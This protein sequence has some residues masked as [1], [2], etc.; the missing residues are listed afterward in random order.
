MIRPTESKLEC[1]KIKRAIKNNS[2]EEYD[3]LKEETRKSCKDEAFAKK[4]P[5]SI[6][7]TKPGDDVKNIKCKRTYDQVQ[8]GS[9]FI[10]CVRNIY[11]SIIDKYYIKGPNDFYDDIAIT[12][13]AQDSNHFLGGGVNF[14]NVPDFN[15]RPYRGHCVDHKHVSNTKIDLQATYEP[16]DNDKTKKFLKKGGPLVDEIKKPFCR[17]ANG[18]PQIEPCY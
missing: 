9:T 17:C 8:F 14:T 6:T 3:K 15:H 11:C 16:F 1:R 10:Q 12:S 13:T 7:C 18:P 2:P 4:K 5:V